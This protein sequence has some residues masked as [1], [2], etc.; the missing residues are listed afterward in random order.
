MTYRGIFFTCHI[1]N[2]ANMAHW[3][4]LFEAIS[5]A[6]EL[7]EEDLHREGLVPFKISEIDVDGG[8]RAQAL[9]VTGMLAEMISPSTVAASAIGFQLMTCVWPL[10]CWPRMVLIT[11]S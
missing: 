6:N 10:A 7:A 11:D 8:A 9:N 3:I 1:R 5:L 2:I 4:G